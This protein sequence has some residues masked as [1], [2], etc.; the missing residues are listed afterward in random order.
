[1]SPDSLV[2]IGPLQF[3]GVNGPGAVT[4]ATAPLGPDQLAV[5]AGGVR[6]GGADYALLVT[7][8][9]TLDPKARLVT[10]SPLGDA[11]IT[12]GPPSPG[13]IFA[14]T[15]DMAGQLGA[16]VM[17]VLNTNLQSAYVDAFPLGGGGS[18][19]QP[20][21][22]LGETTGAAV[23]PGPTGFHLEW[24]TG[25]DAAGFTRWQE[26]FSAAGV[27]I[28]STLVGTGGS[29]LIPYAGL[30][31]HGSAFT[32]EDN[33][34]QLAGA[35]PVTIPGEPA[36]AMTEV[37]AAALA[38]GT[39]AAVGWVDS[40][41]DY[42][43]LFDSTTDSFGPVIGLDWGGA[44]DIHVVALP[45]GG[46][47]A[48]WMNGGAYKGEVFAADGTGGGI[49]SLAGDVTGITSS[50]DLYTLNAQFDGQLY[51]VG[52]GQTVST[53]DAHYTAPDGVGT[54]YLTGQNQFVTGNDQGDVFW[55]NDTGN[56]LIG[57]TGNDTF[58]IG[59]GGD[60][61]I[62]GGGSDIFKL[63][64]IPWSGAHILDFTPADTIDLTLMLDTIH[65]A[66]DPFANGYLK[67]TDDGSGDA[68]LWADYQFPGNNG[69]WLVATLD[70]VSS[71]SLHYAN[72]LIT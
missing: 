37:A 16:G 53:S 33:L 25:T 5:L 54:I 56:A 27:P 69:F 17:V 29:G 59:R 18:G 12:L 28:A 15:P 57:G 63:A 36:H 66:G 13:D 67:L 50:G 55:S 14:V 30:M 2:P 38:D 35:A 6:I 65:P 43:S 58:Y 40:G 9:A 4:A 68:Q 7:D 44:S 48:S 51:Q 72:G 10:P 31:L 34:A 22:P 61:V 26:D 41:T 45:D 70:G 52:G 21:G 20:L 62:G 49:I 8:P 47:A 60:W 46:F 3:D 32:I 19:L 24:V 1:M 71:S 11:T 42:V 23:F 64:A 39:H